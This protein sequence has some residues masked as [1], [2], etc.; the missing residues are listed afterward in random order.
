MDS[1]P[2]SEGIMPAVTPVATL[3]ETTLDNH[4]LDGLSRGETINILTPNNPN[5]LV[6]HIAVL[7]SLS[8]KG[9]QAKRAGRLRRGDSKSVGAG[10]SAQA[11]AI[12]DPAGSRGHTG[13]RACDSHSSLREGIKIQEWAP[14]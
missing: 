12:D 10:A 7:P 6:P 1:R 9:S 2:N 4:Q 11:I 8:Q 5:M 3:Q 14:S 13:R